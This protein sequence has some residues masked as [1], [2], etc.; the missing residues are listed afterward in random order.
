MKFQ[1]SMITS[2]LIFLLFTTPNAQSAS[3]TP[4]K[5]QQIKALAIEGDGS[6]W[7]FDRGR[8]RDVA[9]KVTSAFEWKKYFTAICPGRKLS[10]IDITITD[11]NDQLHTFKKCLLDDSFSMGAAEINCRG[12]KSNTGKNFTYFTASPHNVLKIR[13]DEEQFMQFKEER[14]NSL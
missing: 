14:E 1:L 6:G 12:V 3:L 8:V 5:L 4:E 10:T 13:Y 2:I 11:E 9:I 7:Q